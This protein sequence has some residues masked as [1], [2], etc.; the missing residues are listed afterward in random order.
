MPYREQTLVPPPAVPLPRS[1]PRLPVR[2]STRAVTRGW[3]LHGVLLVLLLAPAAALWM[4]LLWL[5]DPSPTAGQWPSTSHM[6]QLL[7][8]T[9]SAGWGLY[10][11]LTTAVVALGDRRVPAVAT[12]HAVGLVVGLGAFALLFR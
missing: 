11:V 4:E 7:A 9:W 8:G 6:V 10:A 1:V 2:R 5:D 12:C 3:A